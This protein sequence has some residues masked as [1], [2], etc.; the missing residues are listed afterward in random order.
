MD[1]YLSEGAV[2]LGERACLI[3]FATAE[4]ETSLSLL[5]ASARRHGIRKVRSW[6]AKELRNTPFYENH[7]AILDQR[8]GGGYWLWKPYIIATALAE[9]AEGDFVAYSD[10]AVTVIRPLGPLFELCGDIGGILVFAGHYE[11]L[12]TQVPQLCGSWTK[13]DCF[14]LMD[15][16]SS[17]YHESQMLDAS[18][19]VF[20]KN[21]RSTAFVH[22]WLELCT[23]ARILT[24]LP[25]TCGR[26]N[27]PGF[28]EHR[29][30]QS[31]LSL[32]A[33]RDGLELFRSPS[34]HGNHCKHESVREADEWT[35]VP[36]GTAP[37]YANSSYAT[38]LFHHRGKTHSMDSLLE[39]FSK[40]SNILEI[41]T[42]DAAALVRPSWV[43]ERASVTT[44]RATTVGSSEPI[45]GTP[46][47]QLVV[48]DGQDAARV[49]P[50]LEWV[51]ERELLDPA[52]FV[53]CWTRLDPEIAGWAAFRH[54][55]MRLR[56]RI[57]T[58]RLSFGYGF[59]NGWEQGGDRRTVGIVIAERPPN[60][61]VARVD[62]ELS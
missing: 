48:F 52:G 59:V 35:R 36:Y 41:R 28:V 50:E 56:E 6:L 55:K 26:G 47:F 37:I 14:I 17:K 46:S 51:L 54:T 30:D 38:L 18:F 61:Q 62:A 29:H 60:R 12:G 8:R 25:N 27:L 9:A 33:A 3:S 40:S 53:L 43:P 16:D 23:D 5:E 10:A 42:T 4:F 57:P 13:R 22:A 45:R 7:R 15:C 39:L 32:L 34:Q 11:S 44:V 2:Q 21:E 19:I 1:P 24:D 20:K 58:L 49:V 31:V